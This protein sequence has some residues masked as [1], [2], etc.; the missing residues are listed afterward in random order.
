[1][2]NPANAMLRKIRLSQHL[3]LSFV[4]GLTMIACG[5]RAPVD[6]MTAARNAIDMSADAEPCAEA[7]FRAAQSLLDQAEEAF[8]ARDYSRARQLADAAT[9]QAERAR[10]AAIDNAE[11]CDRMRNMVEAV[12][13]AQEERETEAISESDPDYEFIP[14]YFDFDQA[15][16][17]EGMRN[18]LNAHAEQMIL[19]QGLQM[20]IEG[21]C[22][23]LGSTEYNL[24]LGDRRARTVKDYMIRRGVPAGRV[25][26]VSY[27]AEMPVSA[28]DRENRRAEFRVRR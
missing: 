18:T 20:Q 22:D 21:H 1:M 26:T 16:L 15:A 7:E 19:G 17:T 25:S 2:S 13:E 8:A 27:G 5:G 10:Q 4:L 14:V 3:L 23:R 28:R 9:L 6:S 11:D 24:A 12:D